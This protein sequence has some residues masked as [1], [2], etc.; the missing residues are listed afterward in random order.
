MRK[1]IYRA[2]HTSLILLTGLL[3]TSPAFWWQYDLVCTWVQ[4]KVKKCSDKVIWLSKCKEDAF[5]EKICKT[6]WWPNPKR[7][8][9]INEG[10]LYSDIDTRISIPTETYKKKIL[11]YMEE[12]P[13]ITYAWE[14][15]KDLDFILM[16]QEESLWQEFILWDN[17]TSIGYCQ[18]SKIHG[19][20]LYE[21]YMNAKDWKSRITL[22][23]DHYLKFA[24]NVGVVF[25]GWNS[26][27]RNLPSFTFK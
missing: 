20:E 9:A 13:V 27:M 16:I 14:K 25:H 18:I 19:K 11:R 12:D 17:G 15:W 24:Y 7:S 2:I 5:I 26:R 4:P 1:I 22:C 10:E 23:H 8:Y 3:A 6:W 21:E